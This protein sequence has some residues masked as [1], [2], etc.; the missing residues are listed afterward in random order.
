MS[1]QPDA[2][3]ND[4]QSAARA[5]EEADPHARTN[6]YIHIK[7]TTVNPF[8]FVEAD[9]HARTNPY[10]HIKKTTVNPLYCYNTTLKH[11]FTTAMY[12]RRFTSATP[13]ETAAAGPA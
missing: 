8:A 3:A 7:K 12:F 1:T 11:Y 2:R 9:P 6:P 5:N 10:I 4:Y 13:R